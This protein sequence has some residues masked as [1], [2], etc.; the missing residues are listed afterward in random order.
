MLDSIVLVNFIHFRVDSR[1]ATKVPPNHDV[2]SFHSIIRFIV[3]LFNTGTLRLG[4]G[5]TQV[6]LQLADLAE[7][8]LRILSRHG[9]G[10]DHVLPDRPVDRGRDALL[11]RGLQSVN[12]T[13]HLGGV[14]ASRGRVEHS[15]T[16]LLGGVDDEN[17][18]DGERNALLGDVVKVPLV[19]H[20]IEESDFTVGIGDDGEL[21]VGVADLVDVF[22]P[23]T[24]G[25]KFVGTL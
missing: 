10:H 4:L 1:G 14:S 23:L 2:K 22:H 5:V 15:Q 8:L 11:I 16:D 19:D 12:N 3:Q 9:G 20:V 18:T 7:L 24:V 25:V 17:G 13:Q 21:N 6:G